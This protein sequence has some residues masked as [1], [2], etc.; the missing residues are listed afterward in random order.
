MNRDKNLVFVGVPTP[1]GRL[2]CNA[3]ALFDHLATAEI[4][5]KKFVC[6]RGVGGGL[7]KARNILLARARESGAAKVLL[8]DADINGGP[9]QVERILKHDE[10]FVCGLYPAKELV[11]PIRWVVNWAKDSKADARGLREAIEVGAG[12]LLIDLNSLDEV[13]ASGVV[14]D[15]RP[16]DREFD[17]T[18]HHD[19]F[20]EGVVEA[21]WKGDG[22]R[23]PRK[24]TEDFYFCYLVRLAGFKVLVDTVCQLG[25]EGTVDFLALG[26]LI[27]RAR[28]LR[29]ETAKQD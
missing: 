16:D 28:A 22:K 19:F 25:H 10:P 9:A 17:G 8:I 2:N 20:A 18:V 1:D 12:W 26:Q 4:G 27:Q 5:G 23:Y 13:I 24:L 21:D 3:E 6:W 11:W 29:L 15:Y 14:R 7:G